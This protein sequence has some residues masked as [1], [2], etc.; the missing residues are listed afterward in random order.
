MPT[1]PANVVGRCQLASSPITAS[2]LVVCARHGA[3]RL[4][5]CTS[6]GFLQL[7]DTLCQIKQASDF[8]QYSGAQNL[9]LKHHKDAHGTR[10]S[11]AYSP[12]KFTRWTFRSVLLFLGTYTKWHR[13]S[14][15]ESLPE[16]PVRSRVLLSS[17]PLTTPLVEDSHGKPSIKTYNVIFQLFTFTNICASFEPSIYRTTWY[18]LRL[19]LRVF[20]ACI[21]TDP[22]FPMTLVLLNINATSTSLG[23]VPGNLHT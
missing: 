11:P 17:T 13:R 19:L 5:L 8:K 20:T 9:Y 21:K 3:K 14:W 15:Y 6:D 4:V 23:S 7:V 16:Q 1:L 2:I 12:S 18:G 22:P 10:V